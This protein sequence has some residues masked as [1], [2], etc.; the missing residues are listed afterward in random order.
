[1]LIPFRIL[2]ERLPRA[3][4]LANVK[5]LYEFSEKIENNFT[6]LL[7]ILSTIPFW[8]RSTINM[9]DQL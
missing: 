7:C 6:Q 2:K 4:N 1:M 8:Q 5:G 3:P 9:I